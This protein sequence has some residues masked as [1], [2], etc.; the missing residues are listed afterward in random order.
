MTIL[1]EVN[2]P[3]RKRATRWAHVGKRVL[4]K[5]DKKEAILRKR[6]CYRKTEYQDLPSYKR[7]QNS[8]RL[9]LEA[10]ER[11]SRFYFANSSMKL[12]YVWT[13]EREGRGSLLMID[14]LR[15]RND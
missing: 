2:L 1:Q 5:D 6:R 9:R 14:H 7:L 4:E 11:A 15:C 10:F 3:Q 8:G 12:G 13:R